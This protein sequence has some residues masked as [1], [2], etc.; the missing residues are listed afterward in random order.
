MKKMI[1]IWVF[2]AVGLVGTLTFIDPNTK[3]YGALG[4]EIIEKTTGQ[5]LE[6]KDGK[7][8]V[9]GKGAIFGKSIAIALKRVGI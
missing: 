5:R 9:T 8:T 4:H 2:L 6:I 1:I 7:I 3:L